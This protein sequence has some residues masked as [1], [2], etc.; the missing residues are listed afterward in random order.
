M[1]DLIGAPDESGR[2]R[3]VSSFNVSLRGAVTW[4]NSMDAPP[5]V[6]IV[7]KLATPA[8]AA[9]SAFYVFLQY[10]RSQRWKA[11]DLAATLLERLNTDQAL[12]LACQALDWGV[13]PLI[14]PD[15]YRPLFRSDVSAEAPG[16]MEHDPGVLCLA[17]QPP[18]NER[19]LLDPR[20]LVY[21]YCFITLFNYLDN[22]YK[23]LK[24]GQVFDSDV[25]EIKYWLEM[26]RDYKY[27]PNTI[28]GTQVFQP[29]IRAWGYG[30]V[31]RLG[32]RLY[33]ESW[34][35]QHTA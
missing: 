35:S 18:L 30:N 14:I 31:I 13:G 22:M 1:G 2:A 34:T 27:A 17:V 29:A 25:E 12:V 15:K 28:E 3:L 10:N 24:D 19:T 26:L 7:N 33:V 11:T 6:E 23:L 16:V 9:V 4:E 21:R 5:W 32:H 8:I 20:G